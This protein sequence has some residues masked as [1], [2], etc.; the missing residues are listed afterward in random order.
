MALL[1]LGDIVLPGIFIAMCLRYD[2]QKTIDKAKAHASIDAGNWQ[3]VHKELLQ[4][5]ESAP[6][7]YFHGA[8]I[9]YLLAIL[10]TVVVM[11]IFEHGQPALLYLVPACLLSVLVNAFRLGEIRSIWQ[12][13]EET[14]LQTEK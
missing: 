12:Y 14:H 5:A 4:Q 8:I 13:Q 1:G 10:A 2:I 9:S 3:H 7:P 11:L 6:R